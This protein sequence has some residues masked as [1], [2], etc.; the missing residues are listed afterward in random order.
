MLP[1]LKQLLFGEEKIITPYYTLG[2]ENVAWVE[3][4]ITATGSQSKEAGD[5][6]L[7]AEDAVASAERAYVT[8]DTMYLTN[9]KTLYIDWENTGMST[10][11]NLS[12][13]VVSPLKIGT[14]NQ[15]TSRLFKTSTFGRL[16]EA[17]D[18]SALSGV[19]YIRVNA[20]DNFATGARKSEIRVFRVWGES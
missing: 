20:R 11:V 4:V 16:V 14:V 5:L 17:L 9:I 1:V 15:Y 2:T 7:M 13:F 12:G 8:D 10:P 19:F 3:G 6:Y 18:V